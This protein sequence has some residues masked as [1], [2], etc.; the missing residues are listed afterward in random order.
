MKTLTVQSSIIVFIR[1]TFFL[2][3]MIAGYSA[4]N[5]ADAQVSGITLRSPPLTH[6][7]ID[8]RDVLL[9]AGYSYSK[10]ENPGYQVLNISP[11]TITTSERTFFLAYGIFDSLALG[12][13]TNPTYY[14][15]TGTYLDSGR[16]VDTTMTTTRS[17]FY[18]IPTLYKWEKSRIALIWGKGRA[19]ISKNETLGIISEEWTIGTTGLVGEFF[20]GES[21]S[22]VPWFSWPYLLFDII[23]PT[24]NDIQV[25]DYGLDGILYMG[26]IKVSL[27]FLIQAL[28]TVDKAAEEDDEREETDSTGEP[29]QESYAI[30]FSLRF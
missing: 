12:I 6:A 15:L 17:Y 24:L 10:V 29:T 5:N 11:E 28:D 9:G 4:I 20:L 27:T 23:P 30:S 18:I 22:I 16:D 2:G 13:S 26:D 14:R 1:A 19:S 7:F 21:F 8:S 3:L 25:P